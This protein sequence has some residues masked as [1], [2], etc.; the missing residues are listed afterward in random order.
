MITRKL[1]TMLAA[2]SCAYLCANASSEEQLT[3]EKVSNDIYFDVGIFHTCKMIE[4]CKMWRDKTTHEEKIQLRRLTEKD[5]TFEA[6]RSWLI[7]NLF[8]RLNVHREI[9]V[10]RPEYG[11]DL[12]SCSEPVKTMDD[13]MRFR[14]MAIPLTK[15][16]LGPDYIE[17]IAE[18]KRIMKG[19][20]P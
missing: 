9:P 16:T 13:L 4:F 19:E 3:H 14:L 8:S 17:K 1:V 20:K 15:E 11:L 7:Q 6:T 2:L 5:K 10:Q 12:W 18:L